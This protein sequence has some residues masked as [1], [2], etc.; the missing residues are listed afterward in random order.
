MILDSFNNKDFYLSLNPHFA[1][2]FDFL[3]RPDLAELQPGKHEVDGDNIFVMVAHVDGR[4]PEDAE[5]EFHRNYIDIQV[6]LQGVDNIGWRP[7][8]TCETISKEYCPENDIGFVKDQPDAFC[9]IRKGQ[10]AIFF[11]VDAHAPV[12]ADEKLH[13]VIVKVA[14]N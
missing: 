13:K 9:S 2:A 6:C 7:L 3:A 5:L 14:V 4:K 8:E 1:K 10:F 12:I 11:P